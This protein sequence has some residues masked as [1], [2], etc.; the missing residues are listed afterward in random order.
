MLL[1]FNKE[2]ADAR[3]CIRLWVWPPDCP[4]WGFRTDEGEVGKPSPAEALVFPYAASFLR[5]LIAVNTVTASETSNGSPG[6]DMS[7]TNS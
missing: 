2:K 4:E 6:A 1:E 5:C 7:S 3:S